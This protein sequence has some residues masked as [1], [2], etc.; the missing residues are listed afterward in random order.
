MNFNES[1]TL[2][3]GQPTK[4]VKAGEGQVLDL[5]EA[6]NRYGY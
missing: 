4:V 3:T 6:A 1:K 2:M 5:L